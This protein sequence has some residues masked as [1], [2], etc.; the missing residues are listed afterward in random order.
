MSAG[1]SQV[2]DIL[3]GP[4][5]RWVR[6]VEVRRPCWPWPWGDLEPDPAPCAVVLTVPA[7]PEEWPEKLKDGDPRHGINERIRAA[8][9]AAK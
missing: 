5:G 2:G 9:E 8:I 1:V 3:R 6:V 7:R 4:T